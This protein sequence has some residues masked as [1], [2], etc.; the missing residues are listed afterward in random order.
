MG[1][2]L[3]AIFTLG[4]DAESCS[5][6]LNAAERALQRIGELTTARKARGLPASEFYIGL[7]LGEVMYGN[8]GA[9]DRLDFTVV[10]PAVNEVSRMEAMCRSLE[11]NLIV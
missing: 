9:R 11:P 2:G 7:H 5:A 4:D 10:G 1:D 6:A 8:I 3:L